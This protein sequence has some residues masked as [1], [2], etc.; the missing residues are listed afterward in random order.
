MQY[1]AIRDERRMA[2]NTATRIGDAFLSLLSFGQSFLDVFL[3]K[4]VDDTAKG[5]ITFNNG[6]VNK[7]IVVFSEDGTFADGLT[8]HGARICPDG[9]AELDSLTLR[10]FLEVPELRF[11]RVSVHVGNQWRAPGG[12]IIRSVSPASD[13]TGTALLHLEAGEIGTVAVG[14]LCMGIFHSET[15]DDNA[16]ASADDNHGNF[17]FAGFYTAYWE[18]TA[19]ADYTDD[20]TGQTFHNGKVS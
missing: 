3:R 5:R 20:E 7:G 16:T 4:D 18:I 13:A 6:A 1:E 12:G 11:N 19:V 8:G 10:R 15:A 9:S 14:D 17:R 2:A